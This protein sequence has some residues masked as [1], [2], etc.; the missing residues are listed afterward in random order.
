MRIPVLYGTGIE[1]DFT[2]EMK[3]IEGRLGYDGTK[4]DGMMDPPV[5][6]AGP[7]EKLAK[8]LPNDQVAVDPAT[9]VSH[10]MGKSSPEI[11]QAKHGTI[12]RTVKAVVFPERKN[13]DFI[14]EAVH[15]QGLM[16]LP[17]GGGSSVNGSL[18][19]LEDD[20][21]SMDMSRFNE[22]TLN[23]GYAVVGAGVRGID[24]EARLWKAGQTC[25][26]FPESFQY[27]TVGGWLATGATGQESN[28]YGGIENIALGVKL[29]TGKTWI[30][31]AET[32]RESTGMT[33]RSISLGMAGRT[34]IITDVYLKTF[35]IP[36]SRHYQSFFFHSFLEGIEALKDAGSYPT[37]GRLSDATETEF[38]MNSSDQSLPVKLFR[39]YLDARGMSRGS[40][41]IVINNEGRWNSTLRN[42][43]SSGQFPARAWERDRYL[44]PGLARELWKAGYVPDTLETAATWDKLPTLYKD[45]VHTFAKMRDAMGFRGEIM[46]HLSHLYSSGSC[47]YFTFILATDFAD[48][49]QTLSKVRDGLI[50]SFLR[51]G[52]SVTH[53]HGIGALFTQYLDEPHMNLVRMMRDP[54]MGGL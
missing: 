9:I 44:R 16:I 8:I 24:L 21:I 14:I 54:L 38:A 34:G 10:S 30:I 6:D 43:V 25:G 53:H 35:P 12:G 26:N 4:W 52:G 2:S 50:R 37:V 36:K 42:A 28:Q 15:D 17:Y 47:I 40:M 33:A 7:G 32:P 13:L 11:L 41:F 49:E 19:P 5:I 1:R 45:A 31:D 23:R 3:Y 29:R 51:N 22:T 48:E 46:A 27:S 39:R 18:I 20:V